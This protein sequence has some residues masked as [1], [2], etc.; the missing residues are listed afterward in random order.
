M[1]LA[2]RIAKA[3]TDAGLNQAELA[4]RVGVTR[5]TASMWENGEIAALKDKHLMALSE[6]LDVT[7]QWLNTGHGGRVEIGLPA[8]DDGV[9]DYCALTRIGGALRPGRRR[10]WTWEQESPYTP[11]VLSRKLLQSKNLSPDHCRI[12][13]VEDDAMAPY[14]NAGD[15]A[16]IDLAG[17]APR[18]GTVFAIATGAE[19]MLRR[20]ILRAD[21]GLEIRADNPSSR[22][23]VQHVEREHIARIK[24][25]GTVVWRCGPMAVDLSRPD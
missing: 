3:R 2:R 17:T 23:P 12:V 1:T 21:G 7:P 5:A 4:R 8:S 15:I 18:T 6:V 19:M 25:V 20:I 11:V 13:Q 10:A 9:P 22:H 14:L 24:L 16:L